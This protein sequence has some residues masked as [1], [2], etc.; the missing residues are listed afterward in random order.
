[1]ICNSIR[2]LTFKR[3]DKVIRAAGIVSSLLFAVYL[4][5][6]SGI[7]A[8]SKY[9]DEILRILPKWWF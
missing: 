7:Q 6:I 1:M 5:V 2:Y 3:E 9:I 8:G 4:P